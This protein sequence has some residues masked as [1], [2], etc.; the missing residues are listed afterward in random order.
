MPRN[1]I[2]KQVH[3]DSIL[4]SYLGYALDYSY[5]EYFIF[6]LNMNDWNARA[7]SLPVPIVTSR[8]PVL[9]SLDKFGVLSLSSVKAERSTME[10]NISFSFF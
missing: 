7:R 8:Y 10:V 5:I 1:K 6:I 2:F 4:G 9:N 3:N